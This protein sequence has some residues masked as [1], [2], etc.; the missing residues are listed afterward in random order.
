M[1]WSYENSHQITDN[2]A[3]ADEDTHAVDSSVIDKVVSSTLTTRDKNIITEILRA[4]ETPINSA[5]L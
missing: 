4:D 3:A 1:D 5:K 2:E